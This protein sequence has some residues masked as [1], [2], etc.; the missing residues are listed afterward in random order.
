MFD[1]RKRAR[2]V[3]ANEVLKSGVEA[4]KETTRIGEI[5]EQAGIIEQRARTKEEI[6]KG[7]V[8]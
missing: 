4:T 1:L 8:R 7:T 3:R 5:N 2:E 6:T